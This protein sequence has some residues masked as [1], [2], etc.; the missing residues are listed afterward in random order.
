MSTKHANI[1]KSVILHSAIFH[2]E[3][4][5][6]DSEKKCRFGVLSVIER[7]KKYS[8][9]NYIFTNGFLKN[10]CIV[11]RGEEHSVRF[12]TSGVLY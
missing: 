8:E 11:P 6:A 1:T 3:Q 4:R 5:G 9:N 2:V 7:N 10:R 12:C